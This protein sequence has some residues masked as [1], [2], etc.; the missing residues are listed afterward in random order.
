VARAKA[1]PPTA[2]TIC[3]RS[4]VCDSADANRCG[5]YRGRCA[6]IPPGA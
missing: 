5:C 2:A 6:L 3:T 1:R 4:L